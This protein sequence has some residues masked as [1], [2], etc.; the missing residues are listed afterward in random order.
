VLCLCR[1]FHSAQHPTQDGSTCSG[2]VAPA[3]FVPGNEVSPRFTYKLITILIFALV[4][5]SLS[6]VAA[7]LSPSGTCVGPSGC[8]LGTWPN[9]CLPRAVPHCPGSS[10]TL[11]VFPYISLRVLFL[12]FSPHNCLLSVSGDSGRIAGNAPSSSLP[13][14]HPS[15]LPVVSHPSDLAQA[16][17]CKRRPSSTYLKLCSLSVTGECR[18]S[19]S[20]LHLDYKII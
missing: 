13:V 2:R 9:T 18:F 15:T 17:A 11:S 3:L 7:T 16:I 20:R 8:R 14:I 19:P 5:S 1:R 4:S 6:R 12:S 10:Y